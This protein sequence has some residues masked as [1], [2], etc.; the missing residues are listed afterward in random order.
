MFES[1]K[2]GADES[3]DESGDEEERSVAEENDEA[4]TVD[5]QVRPLLPHLRIC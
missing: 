2:G 1:T 4:N 3:G 5:D